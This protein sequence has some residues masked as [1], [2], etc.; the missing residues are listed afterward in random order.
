MVKV[1][2]APLIVFIVLSGWVLVQRLYAGFAARNPELGPF[3]RE[4]GG[5]S[6]G[7]GHCEQPQRSR[8]VAPPAPPS[9]VK[10]PT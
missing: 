8:S 1:L 3:R 10:H 9:A 7:S 2:L 6:C 4:D 5:C